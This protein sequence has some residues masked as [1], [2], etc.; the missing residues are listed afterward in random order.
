MLSGELPHLPD[1]APAVPGTEHK[2]AAPGDQMFQQRVVILKVVFQVGILNQ[3]IISGSRLQAG[4]H[5]MAFSARLFFQNQFHPRMVPW[6]FRATSRV[7]S[8]ELLSTTMISIWRPVNSLRRRASIKCRMFCLVICRNNH[9]KH[10]LR[11]RL[12]FREKTIIPLEKMPELRW[13]AGKFTGV[14]GASKCFFMYRS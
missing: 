7:P 13:A 9:G 10:R 5:G 14:I 4:S 3:H 2:R 6:Y 11:P 12:R 1:I 8:V